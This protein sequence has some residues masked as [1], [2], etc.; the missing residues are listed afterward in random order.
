MAV[1]LMYISRVL[2]G[3]EFGKHLSHARKSRYALGGPPA[4]RLFTAGLARHSITSSTMSGSGVLW[5][6]QV[7][8]WD[9]AFRPDAYV[10]GLKTLS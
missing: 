7:H 10:I 5:P 6:Y 4:S 1:R 9:R 3:P 8:E 2:T